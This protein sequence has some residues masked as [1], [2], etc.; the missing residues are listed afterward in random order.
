MR[1]FD[2]LEQTVS[3]WGHLLILSCAPRINCFLRFATVFIDRDILDNVNHGFTV[4]VEIQTF[5]WTKL[6]WKTVHGAGVFMVC[7]T[8]L[9]L[10]VLG[11]IFLP[12]WSSSHNMMRPPTPPSSSVWDA[13]KERGASWLLI[14]PRR[15]QGAKA[16]VTTSP[17]CPCNMFAR[18]LVSIQNIWISFAIPTVTNWLSW[19]MAGLMASPSR[20]IM[21]SSCP[22][23]F[24]W[25]PSK[26]PVRQTEKRNSIVCNRPSPLET[27]ARPSHDRCPCRTWNRSSALRANRFG[28]WSHLV[29]NLRLRTTTG[30]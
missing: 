27:S 1:S 4:G 19:L 20:R 3:P 12:Y 16:T 21:A 28:I 8:S 13:S 29:M 15:R 30:R 22:Q 25:P 24:G 14:A 18:S 9:F 5:E 6:A 2:A 17:G 7:S 26:S 10:L 23:C 11:T